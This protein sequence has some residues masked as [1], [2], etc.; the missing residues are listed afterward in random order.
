MY[1]IQNPVQQT[2]NE[3]IA[4]N[5]RLNTD[6][7]G[8]VSGHKVLWG[9]AEKRIWEKLYQFDWGSNIHLTNSGKILALNVKK[10]KISEHVD[11]TTE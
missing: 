1:S 9:M 3:A 4:E 11:C 2:N 5:N 7:D 8:K 10:K 6:I